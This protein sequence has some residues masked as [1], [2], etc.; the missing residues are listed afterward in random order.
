M[1]HFKATG[2]RPPELDVP[3][4]PPGTDGLLQAFYDLHAS[5]PVG[6]GPS[7]IPFSEI[8]AWQQAMNLVLTPWEAETL[9]FIDRAVLALLIE[10][11]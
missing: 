8:L 5:R 6:M 1:A 7:A 2:T 11:P 4:L 9:L 10:S 3:L